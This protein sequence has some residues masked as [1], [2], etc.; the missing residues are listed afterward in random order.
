MPEWER[1]Q[2]RG[3]GGLDPRIDKWWEV[4]RFRVY[5]G[6]QIKWGEWKSGLLP[7]MTPLVRPSWPVESHGI[8]LRD[9]PAR[10]SS[11]MFGKSPQA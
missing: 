10:L 1:K 3:D 6:G 8:A 9:R 5:C 7:V 11:M 2:A 4:V